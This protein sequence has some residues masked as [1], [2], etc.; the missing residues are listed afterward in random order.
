MKAKRLNPIKELR[1]SL[2][3]KTGTPW[4]QERLAREL[5]ISV[6]TVASW[7]TGEHDPS[8][9]ALEKLVQVQNKYL[10]ERG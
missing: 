1:K 5:G 2:T 7:E 9:M 10:K 6:R 3:K 8:P 4:P